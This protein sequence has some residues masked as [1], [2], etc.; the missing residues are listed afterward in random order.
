MSENS[1][2]SEQDGRHP[3]RGHRSDL[4]R[5]RPFAN[6]AQLINL[7]QADDRDP[8]YQS[9]WVITGDDGETS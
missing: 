4:R 6:S 2:G 1:S 8:P 7:P 9:W 5:P 3:D